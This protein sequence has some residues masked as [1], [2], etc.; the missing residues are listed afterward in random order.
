MARIR[1]IKPEFW[2]SEQVMEL[3]P[4]ARL[5]FV[6]MWNFCDDQGVHPASAK[7]LK[8]E[9]FPSDDISSSDVQAMVDHM[10]EQG[11]IEVFTSAGKS[12]W[13][14]TGWNHQK[15][16]KPTKRYPTPD[17]STTGSQQLG[18]NSARSRRVVGESSAT[19]GKGREE[20]K[21]VNP[22]SL[23]DVAPSGAAKQKKSAGVTLSQWL[24]T[25]KATGEKIVSDYKPLWAYCEKVG[26]PADWVEIA[27][28]RFHDRYTADEKAKRKR[29]TDWRRVFL[30]AVE[31]NWLGLWFFS[32][33]DNQFRL[34]TV[35]VAADLAT[36]EA[37]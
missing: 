1:T 33:R 11:L 19:E 27:W 2:T 26:I 34:S 20:D 22:T 13:W 32:E 36:K 17:F 3:S 30:R 24:Q 9:V 5:A 37:A 28:L 6:G 23:R 18:D 16:E 29:Y 21:E 15:I 35:G 8:A 14:V 12:Y 10:I 4:I 31:E 7:T 25:L